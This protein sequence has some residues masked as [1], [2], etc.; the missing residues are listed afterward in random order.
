VDSNVEITD[1]IICRAAESALEACCAAGHVR[2]RLVK[3][4]PVRAGL[5][6]GSSDAAAVLL[7]L[8]ALAGGVLPSDRPGNAGERSATCRFC[9]AAR[10]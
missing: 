10:R 3:R 5:G 8:P 6:G 7:G 9:T 2:F 4:I 1:N